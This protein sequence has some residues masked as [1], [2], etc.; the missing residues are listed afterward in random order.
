[1]RE[2][3]EVQVLS[4]V[5]SGTRTGKYEIVWREFCPRRTEDQ[6]NQLPVKSSV[7]LLSRRHLS[8]LFST[9]LRC[10]VILSK[11]LLILFLCSVTDKGGS[12]YLPSPTRFEGMKFMYPGALLGIKGL[13]KRILIWPQPSGEKKFFM[14][15]YIKQFIFFIFFY[16]H[17]LICE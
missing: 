5:T 4:C 16:Y 17:S 6:K 13:K 1:M 9:W 11:T 15:F 7:S 3:L 12:V 8:F 10:I 14:L 2:T